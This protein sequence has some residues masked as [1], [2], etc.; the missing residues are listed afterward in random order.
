[1]FTIKEGFVTN[2]EIVLGRKKF[3]LNVLIV[4]ELKLTGFVTKVEIT[5]QISTHLL[6]EILV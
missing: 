5:P 2:V 3:A 4:N 6:V 1:M